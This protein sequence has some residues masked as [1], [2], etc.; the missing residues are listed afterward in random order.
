MVVY[1]DGRDIMPPFP[2]SYDPVA[3]YVSCIKLVAF[4]VFTVTFYTCT[5]LEL[6]AD[7]KHLTGQDCEAIKRSSALLILKLKERCKLSQSA[8]NTV[9]ESYRGLFAT[10][11]QHMLAALRSKLADLGFDPSQTMAMQEVFSEIEKPFDSLVTEHQQ[12]AYF[13]NELSLVVC[14]YS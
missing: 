4:F 7:F 9:V 3:W 2:F 10:T 12:N 13:L 11:M 6:G 5:E 14:W 1:Y 8:I